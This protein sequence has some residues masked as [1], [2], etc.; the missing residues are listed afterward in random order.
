MASGPSS[1]N[2]GASRRGMAASRDERY[3]TVLDFADALE[4]ALDSAGVLAAPAATS[5]GRAL[6]TTT[7][8][9]RRPRVMRR[10]LAATA[11]AGA[12]MVPSAP[13]L[14]G[15]AVPAVSHVR[16]KVLSGWR[17]CGGSTVTMTIPDVGPVPFSI[18]KPADAGNGI[19]T[20]DLTPK[21]LEVRAARAIAAK[22]NVVVDLSVSCGGTTDGDGGVN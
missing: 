15:D 3:A 13:R 17:E 14:S 11:V 22:S 1:A 10:L 12:L 9:M 7:V 5:S 8:K 2:R 20:L 19:T 21:R 4:R 16:A 6:A 18:S